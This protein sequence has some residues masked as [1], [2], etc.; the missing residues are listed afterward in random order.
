MLRAALTSRSCRTPQLV[1]VHSLTPSAPSPLGPEREP[2]AEQVTL[3]NISG[4]GTQ[5]PAS[6]LA[7]YIN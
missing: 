4:P 5:T 7:L 1:Q 2:Q 6:L 3:E